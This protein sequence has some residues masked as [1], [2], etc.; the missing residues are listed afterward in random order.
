M[1]EKFKHAGQE[2]T[3]DAPELSNQEIEA[4]PGGKASLG[5][6]DQIKFEILERTTG[7]KLSIK[8]DEHKYWNSQ[9]GEISETYNQLRAKHLELI[10]Q[11]NSIQDLRTHLLPRQSKPM[12]RM[13][14]GMSPWRVLPS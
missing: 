13:S 11:Q 8:A 10:G 7:D 1:P 2:F 5:Q 3:S 4:V 6:L 14:Q 12:W 9:G